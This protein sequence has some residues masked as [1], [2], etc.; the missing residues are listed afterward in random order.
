MTL[1]PRA[2]PIAALLIAA[3]LAGLRHREAAGTVLASFE[4]SAYLEMDGCIVAAAAAELDPGPLTIGLS[5]FS[6]VKTATP[7]ERV[8]L[9]DGVL[10]IGQTGVDLGYAR[11]WDPAL[12]S[13]PNDLAPVA[14]KNVREAVVDEL[15]ARRSQSGITARSVA[16]GG[17]FPE[18]LACGLDAI[19]A[20]LSGEGSSD[21]AAHAAAAQ[22]AGRGPGLTPS[23]DDLLTGIM[24]AITLWPRLAAPAGGA[25]R[26]RD[27]LVNAAVPHTTRISAAYLVTARQGWASEPWH[28]LVRGIGQGPDAARAAAR[29]ILLIGETSGADA[30]TGFCWAWWRVVA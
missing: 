28:G 20:L 11:V 25:S 17:G 7:G 1:P 9:R 22:I 8:V 15:R 12:P 24:H 29:R 14:M 4:R 10:R 21:A 5:E 6:A 13:L 3:P 27:L 30:L 23:G 26:V 2:D 16:A 19:A 18:A